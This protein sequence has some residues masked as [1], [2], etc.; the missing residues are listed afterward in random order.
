MEFKEE[1]TSQPMTSPSDV[2]VAGA[3]NVDVNQQ[4]IQ[5]GSVAA[6]VLPAGTVIGQP[7]SI[8]TEMMSPAASEPAEP[9]AA[10][11]PEPAVASFSGEPN[12]PVDQPCP[13]ADQHIPQQVQHSGEAVTANAQ[14]SPGVQPQQ[15][16]LHP[17]QIQSAAA[18][19]S[20]STLPQNFEQNLVIDQPSAGLQSSVQ[21]AADHPTSTA[22]AVINEHTQQPADMTS[23]QQQTAIT[24]ETRVPAV[25]EQLPEVMTASV[26][27]QQHVNDICQPLEVVKVPDQ[28][29][30]VAVESHHPPST[31]EVPETAADHQPADVPAALPT[32]AASQPAE[33]PVTSITLEHLPSTV[34]DAAD[35][36]PV[37]APVIP[38]KTQQKVIEPVH[39]QLPPT[40]I[41]S[42]A[43]DQ[44]QHPL[45]VTNITADVQQ[46]CAPT[47][48]DVN[49]TSTQPCVDVQ[50]Q[51][52]SAAIDQLVDQSPTSEH[53]QPTDV[54]SPE[55]NISAGESQVAHPAWAPAPAAGEQTGEHREEVIPVE[56]PTDAVVDKQSLHEDVV[57]ATLND[58]SE[59]HDVSAGSDT[60][61]APELIS[62]SPSRDQDATNQHPSVGHHQSIAVIISL[63][64]C[65]FSSE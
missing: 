57:K 9:Q 39:Q 52:D 44:P 20:V 36:P 4:V 22:A 8:V 50:P 63:L 38:D 61:D 37:D 48:G 32:D 11:L 51:P 54:P 26:A 3:P 27:S 21:Q 31:A 10:T 28:S 59:M 17:S 65:F 18:A 49:V 13:T 16:H 7:Q 14:M 23:A 55:P 64:V 46:I 29:G 24:S 43:V 34:C 15:L 6:D 62:G 58:V 53:L 5:P 2:T 42:D 35:Q 30:S 40:D 47:V 19:E 45:D 56:Q 25:S 1:S 41:T 12:Q 60:D 33:Q